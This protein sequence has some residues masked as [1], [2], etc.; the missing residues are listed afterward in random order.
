MPD[1]KH[2]AINKLVELGI[3][4]DSALKAK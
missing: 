4:T 1:N 2:Q 3:I